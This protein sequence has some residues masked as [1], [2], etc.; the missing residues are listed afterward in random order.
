M[1]TTPAWMD[2]L[3]LTVL[4]AELSPAV[5][6]HHDEPALALRGALG[7]AMQH[8]LCVRAE[9][10]CE[11]CPRRSDCLI[12]SWYEPAR[13]GQSRARP[14]WLRTSAGG[15]VAPERPLTLVWSFLGALPRPSLPLEALHRASA[16]GLG[17][18]RIPHALRLTWR[19]P[20]GWT[21]EG[22][23]QPVL[24]SALVGELPAADQ[25]L[26]VHTTSR[27]RLHRPRQ[28]TALRR[29]SLADLL[30]SLILRVRKLER[31]LQLPKA[32]VWPEPTSPRPPDRCVW[33]PMRVFSA[34]QQHPIDLS[35]ARAAWALE[36]GEEVAYRDL[37]AAGEWLQMGE[38]TSYGLG[39]LRVTIPDAGV[40]LPEG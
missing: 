3:P 2:A 11:P 16:L 6:W 19:S 33:E 39:A 28:E 34:H 36:E 35:G 21:A 17:E 29:P 13:V 30:R 24:L 7:S 1:P 9:P 26:R 23:P 38:K 10:V 5:P 14:F 25:P 8:L 20:S 18:E 27:V 4:R 15:R 12:P 22:W 40:R 32:R 37:L 31:Q